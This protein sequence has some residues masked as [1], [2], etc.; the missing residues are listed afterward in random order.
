MIDH[1]FWLICAHAIAD[2][3]LQ[4]S[5]MA[6][7]KNPRN[8]PEPPTGAKP[9]TIWPAYLTAHALIHAGAA[10]FV[11]GPELG[12][13]VGICHWLQDYIKTRYQF[14]PNIDQLI[15]IVILI[16]VGAIYGKA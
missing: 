3:P 4:P 1:I 2:Y 8:R 15:H 10:A 16:F 13:A 9:A 14:S 6:R 12:L 5:E 11:V 7:Y